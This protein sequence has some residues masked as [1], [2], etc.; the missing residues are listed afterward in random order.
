MVKVGEQLGAGNGAPGDSCSVLG[1]S[2]DPRQGPLGWGQLLTLPPLWPA[3]GGLATLMPR[4]PAATPLPIPLPHPSPQVG[5]PYRCHRAQLHHCQQVFS[6]LRT[7]DSRRL[8]LPELSQALSAAQLV[9]SQCCERLSSLHSGATGL[10]SLDEEST[11]TRMASPSDEALYQNSHCCQ[12]KEGVHLLLR[13]YHGPLGIA[14]SP[15]FLWPRV[16]R[17]I[18]CRLPKPYFPKLP[19]QRW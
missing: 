13:V 8:L 10:H 17:S 19:A 7:K 4:S 5:L 14:V 11:T 16:C 6:K 3:S 12:G 1:Y 2:R 9:E 15:V 18:T